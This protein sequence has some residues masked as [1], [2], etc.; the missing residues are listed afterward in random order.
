MIHR[1]RRGVVKFT[2]LGAA[3]YVCTGSATSDNL[4]P[5]PLL[6]NKK[7]LMPHLRNL[8]SYVKYIIHFKKY[9][10]FDSF[11]VQFTEFNIWP[12][13]SR[14]RISFLGAG[15]EISTI[16]W[17]SFCMS[18]VTLRLTNTKRGCDIRI[19]AFSLSRNMSEAGH[20][21]CKKHPSVSFYLQLTCTW[22]FYGSV[23]FLHLKTDLVMIMDLS[24]GGGF[25][26]HSLWIM[27]A[28]KFTFFRKTAS[29]HSHHTDPETR[30]H[31]KAYSCLRCWV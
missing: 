27:W 24:P 21:G 1:N 23:L 26:L 25:K 18:S 31:V 7:L 11:L 14:D 9:Y 8:L 12:S 10:Q 17:F 6:E 5:H 29:G 13:A 22:A 16:P 4:V 19:T 15:A 20:L 3:E 2:D 28:I 30:L